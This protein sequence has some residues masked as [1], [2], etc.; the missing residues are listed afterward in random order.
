MV[1]RLR[2]RVTFL[3]AFII[4]LTTLVQAMQEKFVSYMRP[5]A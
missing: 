4:H 2:K 3:I 1:V 5:A